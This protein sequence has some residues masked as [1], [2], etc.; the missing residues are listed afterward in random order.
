MVI[1]LSASVLWRPRA[2]NIISH[3]VDVESIAF[4]DGEKVEEVDAGPRSEMIQLD[5]ITSL[6]ESK[7]AN[8]MRCLSLFCYKSQAATE[9][10]DQVAQTFFSS[11]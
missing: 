7:Q 1:G 5:F 10:C 9:R 8:I 4:V 3:R 6:Y 11:H 2:S